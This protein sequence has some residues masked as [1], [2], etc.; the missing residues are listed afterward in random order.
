VVCGCYLS[1]PELRQKVTQYG[2]HPGW[3]PT[4]GSPLSGVA[5]IRAGAEIQPPVS[6][7]RTASLLSNTFELLRV[8]NWDSLSYSRGNHRLKRDC[9]W[10]HDFRIRIRWTVFAGIDSR[11]RNRPPLVCKT[12]WSARET[13]LNSSKLGIGVVSQIEDEL[14]VSTGFAC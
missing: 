5:Q 14:R 9:T 10:Q 1:I 7:H 4:K 2:K 8:G 12:S 6:V 13:R 11:R 3:I